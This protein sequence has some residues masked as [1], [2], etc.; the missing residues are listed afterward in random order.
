MFMN[1]PFKTPYEVKKFQIEK[2]NVLTGWMDVYV[3]E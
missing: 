2:T 3:Y 1:D